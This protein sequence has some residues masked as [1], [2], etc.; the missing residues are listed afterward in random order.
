MGFMN[1]RGQSIRDIVLLVVIIAAMGFGF[2]LIF[3]ITDTMK[4]QL[5]NNTMINETNSSSGATNVINAVDTINDRLDY[6]VLVIFLGF[7]LSIIVTGYFIP[8]ESIF[9]WLYVLAMMFGLVIAV[10]AQDFWTRS[11][12]HPLLV[13]IALDSFPITTHLLDNITIYYTIVAGVALIVTYAKPG[14]DD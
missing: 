14:Q 8:V 13:N 9:F 2:L 5:L 12:S 6:V 1:K 3:N 11:A 4:G 10:V 7:I